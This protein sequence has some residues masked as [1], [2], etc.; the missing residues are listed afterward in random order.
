MLTISSEL[1]EHMAS[2]LSKASFRDLSRVPRSLT[3]CYGDER[4]GEDLTALGDALSNDHLLKAQIDFFVA[5]TGCRAPSVAVVGIR[6]QSGLDPMVALKGNVAHSDAISTNLATTL[7]RD[8]DA[9]MEYARGNT[10]LT[11]ERVFGAGSPWQDWQSR[12]LVP[13]G[14]NHTAAIRYSIPFQSHRSLDMYLCFADSLPGNKLPSRFAFDVATLP[15]AILWMARFDIIDFATA[16]HWLFML[17]GLTPAKLFLI[18]E[19]VTMPRYRPADMIDRA[20]LSKRTIDNHLYQISELLNQKVPRDRDSS[21]YGSILVDIASNYG[22][23]EHFG[24]PVF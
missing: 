24:R 8:L 16:S 5:A 14:M 3:R 23:L 12:T 11:T 7:P 17:S 10:V 21:G 4:I 22:F 15:F 18:R 6:T 20:G 9:M 19:I 1:P 2:A 13:A